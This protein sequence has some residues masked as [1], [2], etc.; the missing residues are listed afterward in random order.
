ML[1]TVG[2]LPVM[3]IGLA[4]SFVSRVP[5]AVFFLLGVWAIYR[6]ARGWMALNDHR[7][8]PMP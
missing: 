1:L 7:A 3:L 6:I 4:N 5:A 2:S 8:M